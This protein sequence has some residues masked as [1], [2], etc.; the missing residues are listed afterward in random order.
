MNTVAKS[1]HYVSLIDSPYLQVYPDSGNLVNAA[2]LYGTRYEDD[3][4]TGAGHIAAL[5][6]KETVP[7]K[8]RE[9]P[10]GTGHVPFESVI[11]QA[12]AMGIRRYTAEFWYVGQ[13]NWLDTMKHASSFLRAKFPV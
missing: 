1:M 7:G 9:I 11:G 8:Y 10:F 3:F 2:V 5:H 4:N 13:E 6:L 12:W